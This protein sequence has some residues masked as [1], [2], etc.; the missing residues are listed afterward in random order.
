MDR[1]HVNGIRREDTHVNR[2]DGR[3][4]KSMRVAQD[5]H[6]GGRGEAGFEM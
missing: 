4:K 1:G 2:G 3:K 6:S 5:V